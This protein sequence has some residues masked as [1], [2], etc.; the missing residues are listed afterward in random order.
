[1]MFS[2]H[3]KQQ[4]LDFKVALVLGL[5]PYSIFTSLNSLSRLFSMLINTIMN[6]FWFLRV[7]ESSE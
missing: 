5:L 1:M 6:I 2:N 4:A 3:I 7:S